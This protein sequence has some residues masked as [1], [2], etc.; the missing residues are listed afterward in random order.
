MSLAPWEEKSRGGSSYYVFQD[1][2]KNKIHFF[3]G[4]GGAYDEFSVCFFILFLLPV[5]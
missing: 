4:G 5:G 3:F 2:E 1:S